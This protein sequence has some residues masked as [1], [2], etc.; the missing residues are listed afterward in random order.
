MTFS[1]RT[2]QL[3]CLISE[4]FCHSILPRRCVLCKKTPYSEFS[5]PYFSAF[6]LNTEIYSVNLHI[7]SKCRKKKD[8]KNSEYANFS[9]SSVP[10]EVST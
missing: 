9:C 5:G 2:K 1:K 3:S 8:Q 7:Q 6:R 10:P 4:T